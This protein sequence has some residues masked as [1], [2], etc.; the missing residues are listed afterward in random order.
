MQALRRSYRAQVW[1][2]LGCTAASLLPAPVHGQSAYP[3]RPI[4][5]IIPFAAGGAV[6]IMARPIGKKLQELTGQPIVID[7]RGGAGGSIA[8]ELTAK[9]P[10][11]GYT[12]LMGSTSPLAI[13]P[14]YFSKLSYDPIKD[15]TP[16][17]M[18]VRQPLIIVA[19]PS[20]PVRNVKDVVALAKRNPGKLNYGSA[21]LGTSNHLVGEL[22]SHAAGI[23]M[24]HVPFKGG[25]P[26]LVAL[27]GGE[28]EL[29]ISQPNT[30]MSYVKS[31]RVRAIA[32]TGGKR[33]PAYPDVGTLV[34][35]GYKDLDIMG[36]YC[37][38]GPANLPRPIVDRLNT[39]I[40]RTIA[41]PEV[42]D[43]LIAEGTEPITTSPE[44]LGALMK[45]DLDRW[46]KAVKL[47]GIKGD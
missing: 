39:E 17:S 38:V 15:F 1:M 21:G 47:A 3:T 35:A 37:I 4:R 42:R 12:L 43:I 16:I 11:D 6:D 8:A 18:I 19:H 29:Q 10:P 44:E 22:L 13:N 2:L 25:A 26:A 31:G 41:S 36:W 34:E 9:S 33:S 30:M 45:A 28:I 23:K 40:R 24:E 32:T 7:N 20:L 5:M 46:T 27:L 14:A